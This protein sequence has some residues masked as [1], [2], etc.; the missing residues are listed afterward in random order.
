MDQQKQH[1]CETLICHQ[2]ILRLLSSAATQLHG[3][4]FANFIVGPRIYLNGALYFKYI[5]SNYYTFTISFLYFD[6]LN[7][8]SQ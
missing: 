3:G 2:T 1:S 8:N 7:T 4:E 6:K 5:Y